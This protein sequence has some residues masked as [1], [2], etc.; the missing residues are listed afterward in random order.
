MSNWKKVC[1]NTWVLDV[2]SNGYRIPLDT[3]PRQDSIPSNPVVVGEAH[4]I[5]VKEALTLKEKSAISVVEHCDGEYIS[6][7][8]SVPKPNRPGQYRPILNLKY[9][10]ENV[11]KYKFSMESVFVL[12]SIWQMPSYI[13]HFMI[14]QRNISALNGLE[15][16]WSGK[17]L[18]LD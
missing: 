15:N 16:Y 6:T 4:E 2:I 1:S 5:L 17:L 8:F 11:K 14:L 3:I 9:F 10:N 13:Y 12:A 18:C 7:Y